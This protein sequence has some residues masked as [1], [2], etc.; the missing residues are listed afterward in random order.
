MATCPRCRKR[1]PDEA[2]I[3]EADGSVLLQDESFQQV[4]ADL[5]AGQMAGEYRIEGKIGEGGFGSVYRAMHPLIGKAAAVKVL[6]RQYSANPQMMSRFVAEARAVNQIRNRNIIDI[7]SFGATD[8]G[9]QFFVMELLEGLPLDRYLKQKGRLDPEEVVPILRGVARALDAAHAAGIAHRDLKPENVFLIFEDDGAIFPKLLDFGIAKLLGDSGVSVKTR[10]GQPMG[11]PYYMSPEQCRGK[12]VDH[13]TDIYSF[14]ILAHEMLTG[15]VPFTGDSVMDVMLKQ[16]TEAPPKVS[17]VRVELAKQLDA[18]IL[19]MLRKEPDTRPDSAGAAVEALARAAQEAGYDVQALPAARTSRKS[20]GSGGGRTPSG[21][22]PAEL[23]SISSAQTLV[24][25]R[26]GGQTPLDA[27]GDVAPRGRR[28]TAVIVA[29]VSLVA[30]IVGAAAVASQ[31]GASQAVPLSALHLPGVPVVTLPKV[32]PPE[33]KPA[34]AAEVTLS[35]QATPKVVEVLLGPRKLGTSAETLV[36][37]RGEAP[38]TLTLRAPGYVSKDVEIV[39]SANV[40]LP[41]VLT[42]LPTKGNGSG[43]GEVEW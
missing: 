11:T 3:C 33:V 7:F 18:P 9:R 41:V 1:Y 5:S 25:P 34:E 30:G 21:L 26:S 29:M 14:G 38:V 17:S 24:D 28:W 36:L 15:H 10:T 40:V 37:P 27:S 39:P 43:R 4:D 6:N 8:D 12:H 35:V 2:T 20:G 31:R 23:R 32:A 42:R 13:R 19:E 22:T 16:T